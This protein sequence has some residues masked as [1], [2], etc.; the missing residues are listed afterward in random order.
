[1]NWYS[2]YGSKATLDLVLGVILSQISLAFHQMRFGR[3]DV[4]TF[5][6]PSIVFKQGGQSIRSRYSELLQAERF[7]IR[8]SVGARDFLFSTSVQTGPQVSA[9]SCTVGAGAVSRG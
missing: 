6:C 7:W 2:G 1:M 3:V 4:G 5:Q 8:I 9:A